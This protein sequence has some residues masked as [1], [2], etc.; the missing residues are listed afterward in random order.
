[1]RGG[2][3]GGVRYDCKMRRIPMMVIV[4]G[5]YFLL[6]NWNGD[7]VPLIA[8]GGVVVAGVLAYRVYQS[9][10]ERVRADKIERAD[11]ASLTD[12]V[13]VMLAKT[14]NRILDLE[15]RPGLASSS[16]ANEHFQSAVSTFVS[17]DEDLDG[18][19]STYRLQALVSELDDA[20]WRLDAAEALLDGE[21][22]PPRPEMARKRSTR[23]PSTPS[24]MTLLSRDAVTRWVDSGSRG[25]HRRRRRSC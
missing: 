5:A 9:R 22:P 6:R 20:L 11:V 15:G 2:V 1:M 18:A 24:S 10:T 21:E 13:E 19:T 23:E 25:D 3:S 7:V 8:I 14:A 12:Q 17:A 16:E 4:F